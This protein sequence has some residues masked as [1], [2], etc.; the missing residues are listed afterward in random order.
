MYQLDGLYIRVFFV[1]FL[2]VA[3]A[4]SNI[5][6]RLL[7]SLIGVA[8]GLLGHSALEPEASSPRHKRCVERRVV[9]TAIAKNGVSNS[10]PQ[11]G[12]IS[13]VQTGNTS[14]RAST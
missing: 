13:C 7:F 8:P 2:P 6:S 3:E 10:M 12:W 4:V 9:P 14:G 5:P 1:L 11:D